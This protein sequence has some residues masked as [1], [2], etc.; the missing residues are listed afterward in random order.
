MKIEQ[1]PIYKITVVKQR[2]QYLPQNLR[3]VVAALQLLLTII[4][5]LSALL[6]F[7]IFTQSDNQ[8]YATSFAGKVT[9]LYPASAPSNISK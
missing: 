7:F 5:I 8:Y 3:Y 6:I 4:A 2:R 9:R 1:E